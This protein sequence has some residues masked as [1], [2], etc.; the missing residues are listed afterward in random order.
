MTDYSKRNARLGFTLVE[1]LVVIAI[2]ALLL[3]LAAPA[4]NAVYHSTHTAI[5]GNNLRRIGEGVRSF[6]GSAPW[7]R[8]VTLSPI[9]WQTQLAKYLGQGGVFLCPGDDGDLQAQQGLP[10]A[11]LV[12][13]HS[14]HPSGNYS[15]YIAYFDE[16]SPWVA[17]LSEQQWNSAGITDLKLY[18]VPAY[19]PGGDPMVYYYIFEDWHD[20]A[21][22]DYDY[23]IS[24][25][26]TENGDGTATLRLKQH[27]TGYNHDFIDLIDNNKVI[28]GKS[29]MNGTAS[30]EHTVV[31]GGTGMTSYGMN[32][33][34]DR[35]ANDPGKIIALDYPWLV[36]RSTH[37]W[38]MDKFASDIPGIPIF[39]RHHRQINVLFTDDSV[40]LRRPDEVNPV[41]PGIQTSLWDE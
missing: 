23:D 35:V 5:C 32:A 30:A 36:A 29:Q 21:R 6:Y 22:S 11:E 4:L 20:P 7:G 27:G 39:A 38:S 15:D 12:G 34:I 2:L 19:N 1:L 9:G 33:R 31:I 17:K 40:S 25:R 8:E 10:L 13:F 26:V 37:D 3:A 41:D 14:Y 28:M 24:V 16:S 18:N